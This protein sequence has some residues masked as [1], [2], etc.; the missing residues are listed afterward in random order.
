MG[1][2]KEHPLALLKTLCPPVTYRIASLGSGSRGNA[3]LVGCGDTH[4]LID[5][6]LSARALTAALAQ[7][8]QTP[9]T[10]SAIFIT[11]EHI[12]HVRALAVLAPR[13]EVPVYLTYPCLDA[14]HRA[15]LRA[16]CLLPQPL[17]YTACVGCFTV[18]SFVLSHDSSACVGY[19]IDC[20]T[21][22]DERSMCIA[23][24]TG[25]VT[26]DLRAAARGVQHC[27]LE[28]NHDEH[29][30]MAGRYPY[31]LKRR[32]LS[33][34]GHLSNEACAAFAVELVANGCTSMLLAHLSE[35][36]N[37]PALALQTVQDMLQSVGSAQSCTLQTAMPRQTVIMQEELLPL[38]R[39][40]HA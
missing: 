3:Y 36:N 21:D 37:Y 14:L 2:V 16:E 7:F 23:T 39:S 35:E 15:G 29:L 1:I 38:Q 17:E 33:P 30:L 5:C 18:R 6:G 9:D 13:L 27:I 4:F 24:D 19:R 10:L 12:D 8:G 40:E 31:A 22:T 26:D 34:Q 25:Y 28:A 11:H 20:H 32:I